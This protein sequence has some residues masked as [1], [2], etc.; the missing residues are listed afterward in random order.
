MLSN[1]RLSLC[2]AYKRGCQIDIPLVG[3]VKS[4]LQNGLQEMGPVMGHLKCPVN[5]VKSVIARSSRIVQWEPDH[6]VETSEVCRETG[7]A[8]NLIT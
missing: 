5:T 1:G 8:I 6:P 2:Q 3:P 7:E 4:L